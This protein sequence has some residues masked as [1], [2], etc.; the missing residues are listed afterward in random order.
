MKSFSLIIVLSA[1]VLA[2][3]VGCVKETESDER[4]IGYEEY[5]MVVAS[6][7]LPGIVGIGVNILGEV[8]AIKKDAGNEWTYFPGFIEGFEYEAGYEYEIEIVETHFLDHR[9]GDPAWTEYKLLRVISKNEIQS[10]GLPEN[11]IPDWFLQQ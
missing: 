10:E 2:S 5:T 8:F 1:F 3:M 7:R 4:I 11:F 6:E 9:R